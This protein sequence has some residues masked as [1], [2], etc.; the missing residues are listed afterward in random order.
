MSANDDLSELFRTMAAVL[1]IRG[2]VS[3]KA[4]AFSKVGRLLKDLPEDIKQIH[5]RGELK[6]VDGIGASS[7]KIIEDYLKTGR[8]TDYEEL[9][10]S[11]PSG[12]LPLLNIPSMGP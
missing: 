7:Q 2:E 12:L 10:G 8:S 11:V 9:V 4:I 5:A 3:F 6:N 1:D